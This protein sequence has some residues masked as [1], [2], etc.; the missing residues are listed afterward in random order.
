MGTMESLRTVAILSNVLFITYGL[1]LHLYPVLLLHA[2]LLPINAL[3]MI[4]LRRSRPQNSEWLTAVLGQESSNTRRI[5][6]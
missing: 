6:G 4:Q 2:T 1:E 5:A 3:K